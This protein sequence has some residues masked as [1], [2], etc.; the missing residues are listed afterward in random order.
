MNSTSWMPTVGQRQQQPEPDIVIVAL[1]MTL[2]GP[3]PMRNGI[4]SLAMYVGDSTGN[5]LES[6]SW[7]VAP[8]SQHQ[9]WTRPEPFDARCPQYAEEVMRNVR[10]VIDRRPNAYLVCEN[11][12]RD[13]SFFNAYLDH[14]GL[15]LIANVH[16]ATEYARGALRKPFNLQ[17]MD[18]EIARMHLPRMKVASLSLQSDPPSA[19]EGAMLLYL[20]HIALVNHCILNQ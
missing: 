3:S 20:N 19:I 7:K 4:A 16:D 2:R 6:H 18:Y 8:L 9:C 12:G 13:V 1:S 10:A 14:F 11:A 15:P 17:A 5:M